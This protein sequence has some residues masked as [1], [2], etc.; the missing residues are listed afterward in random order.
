MYQEGGKGT[1]SKSKKEQIPSQDI[2]TWVPSY[3]AEYTLHRSRSVP[4]LNPHI[5]VTN[6]SPRLVSYAY[7]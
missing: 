4:C 6:L 3:F 2:Q 7:G 5:L 1:S